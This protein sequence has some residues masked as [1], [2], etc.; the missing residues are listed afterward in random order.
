VTDN[1]GLT[2]AISTTVTVANVAP[3]I[4]DL[5]AATL[6]P[7]D[8]YV[9]AGSFTD[10]GSDAWSGT[11]DWGDGAAASPIALTGMTFASS[12]VYRSPG[13][14]TVTVRISD[15]H[16]TSS[17]SQVIT[18]LAP[19][20]AIDDAIAL[21]DELLRA[22]KIGRGAAILLELELTV[23]RAALDRENR[24]VALVELRAAIVELDALVRRGVLS[25]ADAAPLRT[26][27]SRVI[28]S[29]ST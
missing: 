27:L 28:R 15:D 1:D 20:R 6:L 12:H 3:V 9:A 21:V 11:I 29:L 26:L 25:A 23:A 4:G 14:F 7:S 19:S 18:V 22:G 10:P 5:P 8:T 24:F 17:R 2:D 13:A 16:E